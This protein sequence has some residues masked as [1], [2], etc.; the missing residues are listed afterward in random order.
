M[1]AINILWLFFLLYLPFTSCKKESF[2]DRLAGKWQIKEMNSGY[3][4][5]FKW[6]NVPGPNQLI[7]EF[8][9]NGNYKESFPAGSFPWQ[10]SGTYSIQN[11]KEV[12]I[13]KNCNSGPDEF[14]V[15]ITDKVMMITY[16]T[17]EG[18]IKEKYNKVE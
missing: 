6:V 12:Q 5:D 15:V 11:D 7:R 16:P 4:S 1:K 2:N 3:W 14:D 13:F 9:T 8:T 17:P 18:E 10:C